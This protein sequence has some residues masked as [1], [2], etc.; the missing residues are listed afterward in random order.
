MNDMNL[1]G[2][3]CK[4]GHLKTLTAK[5][6]VDLFSISPIMLLL[7]SETFD[8]FDPKEVVFLASRF[9]RLW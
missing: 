8:V 3:L 6:N 5:R 7:L 4:V 1:A 9:M 2:F